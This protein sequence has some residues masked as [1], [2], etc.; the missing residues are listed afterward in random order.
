[1]NAENPGLSFLQ[2]NSLF[3]LAHHAR[4]IEVVL[5]ASILSANVFF[6]FSIIPGKLLSKLF[7]PIKNYFYHYGRLTVILLY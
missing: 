2:S 1:M 6:G 5:P 3:S 4:F 7:Y